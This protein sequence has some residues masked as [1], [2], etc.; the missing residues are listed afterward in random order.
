MDES[1]PLISIISLSCVNWTPSL[2][3]PPLFPENCTNLILEEELTEKFLHEALLI[4]WDEDKYFSFCLPRGV[5]DN[6]ALCSTHVGRLSRIF[7]HKSELCLLFSRETLCT[8]FCKRNLHFF[9]IGMMLRQKARK[10]QSGRH[11]VAY[12]SLLLH[13]KPLPTNCSLLA[14]RM[15]PTKKNEFRCD[16]NSRL[17]P[18][19]RL[20]GSIQIP[21]LT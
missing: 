20:Q 7:V 5:S 17:C 4:N 10:K 1:T 2:W 15:R 18:K 12:T 19:I 6:V 14:G 16:V 13:S 3:G 11:N 9:L 21:R 8:I